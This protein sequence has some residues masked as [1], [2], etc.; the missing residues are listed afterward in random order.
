[1]SCS[2]S[3]SLRI[4]WGNSGNEKTRKFCRGASRA[5]PCLGRAWEQLRCVSG[6]RLSHL[7]GEVCVLLANY[8]LQLGLKKNAHHLT[9]DTKTRKIMG[10][11][12]YDF[13]WKCVG[14]TILGHPL[15]F[16][17]AYTFSCR[18]CYTPTLN[19]PS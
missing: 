18:L 9:T 3:R 12:E 6:Q 7:K 4:P 14:M 11:W 5:P 2:V 13:P 10:S 16:R 15:G 19:C 1:M 17:R 8:K